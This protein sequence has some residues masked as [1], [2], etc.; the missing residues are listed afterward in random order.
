MCF[1]TA[2]EEKRRPQ[3]E[4]AWQSQG[5][6]PKHPWGRQQHKHSDRAVVLERG[7]E[8]LFHAGGTSE[9][10]NKRGVSHQV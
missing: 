2:Q 8:A 10:S 9:A 1:L 7:W 4:V 6:E 3:Q 5:S